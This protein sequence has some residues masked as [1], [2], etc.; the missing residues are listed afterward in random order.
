M[1]QHGLHVL[2][3]LG[4]PRHHQPTAI[5]HRD[6]D[7]DQLNRR[8]LLQHRRWRQPWRVD[9]QPVLQRHLQAIRSECDQHV[10]VG[11]VLELMIDRPDS[12]FA[13]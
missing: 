9:L 12:Q 2:I 1:I 10:R 8:Q 13:F 4:V 7:F 6:P 11:P 5:H 3:G